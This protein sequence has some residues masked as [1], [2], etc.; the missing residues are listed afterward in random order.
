MWKGLWILAETCSQGAIV[1]HRWRRRQVSGASRAAQRVTLR[2]VDDPVDNDVD[3]PGVRE[4]GGVM[5]PFYGTAQAAPA[6]A[7][8]GGPATAS[9]AE[10]PLSSYRGAR[11]LKARIA[12]YDSPAAPP[13]VEDVV[14]HGPRAF[15]DTLASAVYD[16]AHQAGGSIPYVVI[17]EIAENL[18]HADFQEAVVT[19]TDGGDTIRFSDQGPG[20]RDKDRALLP[21]FSTASASMKSVIRGVG[22]GLPVAR[23]CLSFNGGSLSLDDN[24][25]QGTV[26]TLSV[27]SNHRPARVCEDRSAASYPRLSTRQKQ[28]LSLSLELGS[29]GPSSVSRE[30][31]I[32]LST[33]YRDLETLERL[34]LLSSDDAG[35]RSLTPL[36]ERV[37]V[38]LLD[39]GAGL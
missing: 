19:I 34:S 10:D 7:A 21:G 35:K 20:I 36:G 15:I 17:R 13:R 2:G 9:V 11:A 6:D 24:L 33:A 18:I 3:I 32:A 26:V 39:G 28:I 1:P 25:G 4:R 14:A 23:E 30:L 29:V 5:R 31:G 22:S 38:R 16:L 37:L 27:S 8:M 12:V